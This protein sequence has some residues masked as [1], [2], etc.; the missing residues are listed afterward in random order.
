MVCGCTVGARNLNL[1]EAVVRDWSPAAQQVCNANRVWGC[2][3]GCRNVQKGIKWSCLSDTLE[4]AIDSQLI[5]VHVFP[6]VF[7]SNSFTDARNVP[8][9]YVRRALLRMHRLFTRNIFFVFDNDFSAVKI[10]HFGKTKRLFFRL[11]SN[12]AML[13]ISNFR[14]LIAHILC[15]IHIFLR[16]SS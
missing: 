11:D 3:R 10:V 12:F 9:T 15:P 4:I 2:T 1:K 8:T 13:F 5:A 16:V 7:K 14:T 6:R